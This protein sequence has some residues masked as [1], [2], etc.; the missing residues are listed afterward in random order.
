[1]GSEMCIR[2][3][4]ARAGDSITVNNKK[5]RLLKVT[6]YLSS[7][8]SDIEYSDTLPEMIAYEKFLEDSPF[9]NDDI[10]EDATSGVNLETLSFKGSLRTRS[11]IIYT[12]R[13]IKESRTLIGKST[14]GVIGR[15]TITT[16]NDSTGVGTYTITNAGSGHAVGDVI[17][18]SNGHSG[19]QLKIKV[20]TVDSGAVVKGVIT[21]S[22]TLYELGDTL[23]QSA[24][25]GSGANFACT[26]SSAP[27]C[28]VTR[29]E[30]IGACK[31]RKGKY[32]VR[33]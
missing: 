25:T 29:A 13:K 19:T 22:G 33:D 30:S 12:G 6:H 26:I 31:A 20:R 27:H 28:L 32:I 4:N 5:K 17:T 8:R 1:M 2:D 14:R 18:M 9:K 3:S 11:A 16:L 10:V 21:V 15:K 23:T 7:R 24:T